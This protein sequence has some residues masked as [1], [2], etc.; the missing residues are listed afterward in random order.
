M[1]TWRVGAGGLK[2]K[3]NKS[4]NSRER[5]RAY[6]VVRIIHLERSFKA[7]SRPRVK[8]LLPSAEMKNFSEIRG[9]ARTEGYF[10]ELP[11]TNPRIGLVFRN[12]VFIE[13]HTSRNM[14]F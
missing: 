5:I 3:S 13:S 4:Q 10:V 9:S 7:N 2:K 11:S 6:V 8:R 12:N 14:R 1:T